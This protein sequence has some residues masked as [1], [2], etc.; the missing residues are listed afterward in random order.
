[1][2]EIIQ[3]Y[4]QAW[5]N[6]DVKPIKEIFC[7]DIIYSECY[8]PEY[9]GISQI[10][11]WFEDWNKKGR[12]LEWRIKQTII[13]NKTIVVEWYFKCIYEGNTDGFDGITI[14]VFDDNNKIASLKEFQ[15]KA[16]HYFPYGQ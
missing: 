4:F 12:V 7:E 6:A 16:N 1:M 2:N 9:H 11:Q 3:E 8:G 15:S 5:I 13:H 14:A 10:I